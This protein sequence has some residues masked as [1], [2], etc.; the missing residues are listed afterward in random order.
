MKR[1]TTGY[2]ASPTMYARYVGRV[3]ALAVALGVGVAVA[4]TPGVAW[5]DETS[6][7][8]DSGP[9]A[10]S[11]SETDTSDESQD[12]APTSAKE[13]RDAIEKRIEKRIERATDAVRKIVTDVAKSSGEAITSTQRL[14]VRPTR[15]K[16]VAPDPSDPVE[17]AGAPQ[18]SATNGSAAA[19]SDAALP[20]STA[21][22]SAT[23]TPGPQVFS[24]RVSAAI[25]ENRPTATTLDGAI[26]RVP[27]T[28]TAGL[29]SVAGPQQ[30]ASI[31]SGITSVEQQRI[32][33][34]VRAPLSVV[35]RVLSAALAPFLGAGAPGQPAP[36]NPV[37][38]GVLAW[39]RR[40][41]QTSLLNDSPTITSSTQG[42]SIDPT[43]GLPVVTGSV[44]V[45]DDDSD[46]FTYTDSDGAQGGTVVVDDE[47]NWTYTPPT[48]WNANGT[49]PFTDSFT[50]T[51]SDADDG[52][53]LH[54]LAA[55]FRPDGGHTAT[56]QTITVTVQPGAGTVDPD[57][58]VDPVTGKAT[59]PVG[60]LSEENDELVRNNLDDYIG[61][62]IDTAYGTATITG[63]DTVTRKF[64]VEY[65]P[66]ANIRVGGYTAEP[67]APQTFRSLT[68]FRG[69][70]STNT[71]AAAALAPTTDT[72]TITVGEGTDA[73][74][75]TIT[76]P[77][78]Q[79]RLR[80]END[81]IT[82]GT[83]PLSPV[84][85]GD[86]LFVLSN[87]DSTITVI[88]TTTNTVIDTDP[89]AAGTN[90]IVTGNAVSMVASG[91]RL[92]VSESGGTLRVF[93]IDADDPSE[94]YTQ[95]DVD[96]STAAIDTIQ[97]GKQTN[98]LPQSLAVNDTG[99]RLYMLNND[100][101]VSVVNI[102][103]ADADGYGKVLQSRQIALAGVNTPSGLVVAGDKLYVTDVGAGN[104]RVFDVRQGTAG[105]GQP[106]G[107]PIQVGAAPYGI[108]KTPA[109]AT[110][111]DLY[112]VN[113]TTNSVSIIDTATDTVVATVPVGALPTGVAFSPDGS[114][115]YVAGADN[116]SIIDTSSRQFVLTTATDG[117]PDGQ[118]FDY[119][120][121][122]EDHI[123]LT[124]QYLVSPAAGG[125]LN[126]QLTV[127]SF[128]AGEN[129]SAPAI[130]STSVQGANPNSGAVPVIVRATDVDGDALSV[131]VTQ[132]ANGRVK[133]TP[134]A[135][136]SYTVTYTPDGQARLDA[137]ASDDPITE[138]FVITVSDGQRTDS[139]DVTVTVSPA[140]AAVTETR[141][142]VDGFAL[143]RGAT[144]GPDGRLRLI[145]LRPG[146]IADPQA[147]Y[148]V[149]LVDVGGT[150]KP[151][152]LRDET[153]SYSNAVN[154]HA[155]DVAVDDNGNTYVLNDA[156][157]TVAV[158]NSGAAGTPITFGDGQP[159]SLFAEDDGS[160]VYAIVLNRIY[161]PS[162]GTS[163]LEVSVVDLTSGNQEV[164]S[165]VVEN[166]NGD[167]ERYAE[168]AVANDGTV[169]VTNYSDS[170]VTVISGGTASTV[171][172][173]GG[174]PVGVAV[175]K[176]SGTAYVVVTQQ[177]NPQLTSTSVV[178][179]SGGTASTL[180][181]DISTTP[182]A[183]SS[184]TSSDIAVSPDG[185]RIYVTNPTDASVTVIDAA[186]GTVLP[187][188]KVGEP[189]LGEYP[190]RILFAPDGSAAY[191][192]DRAGTISVVTFADEATNL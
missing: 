104:V 138:T 142:P 43:S 124:D 90:P 186:T 77:I 127:V 22:Q 51:V 9:A 95:V 122:T 101:T 156:T 92:Y 3:G 107:A 159:V 62:R 1:R 182:T 99:T 146:N 119:V 64:T 171:P 35:T 157:G 149:E 38:W 140:E 89:I 56:T 191:V 34:P 23:R 86:R 71:L 123:Y 176:V 155:D 151:I 181:A 121:A 108:F 114:L 76:V 133:V 180:A 48:T 20:A 190:Q 32:T 6:T 117:S 7:S 11:K 41:V 185:T 46:E 70:R 55:L 173:T 98:F 12:D 2:T 87:R 153:G 91:G 179:I 136:G 83:A 47:G 96:P 115:A 66:D 154:P 100:R 65:V 93:E 113:A 103:P 68:A 24:R 58:V 50:V 116:L 39:V 126:N 111:S 167:D 163:T 118:P 88:D 85:Y 94:N 29:D 160:S 178:K 161:D 37:L 42:Q 162:V 63:Y 21:T 82:V 177:V 52:R 135:D 19:P 128:F 40:Q 168:G 131:L 170:T 105:Y 148:T 57:T 15:T 72:V 54:G 73:Q 53:H 69:M 106:V 134:N 147:G 172:V 188:I 109:G 80:T 166:F 139:T 120:V 10:S 158:Y 187:G 28:V 184:L 31:V 174:R 30:Q 150:G 132:P 18:S 143:L 102:D 81:A 112:V 192:V 165:Y 145:V 14:G 4:S 164:G 26:Q 5:A 97:T 74:T 129:P 79:A 84:L 169:Y 61:R 152:I 45:N 183:Y 59:T 110:H 130:T 125:T 137:Y 33:A 141:D 75:F 144:L 49:E 13:K 27:E 16:P 44:D 67:P 25:T 60:P 175:D 189:I 78:T 17:G 8:T 36:Q